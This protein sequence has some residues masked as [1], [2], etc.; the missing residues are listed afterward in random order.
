MVATIGASSSRN[1]RSRPI[2][3]L[4]RTEAAPQICSPVATK[5]HR[6][7][8]PDPDP[9]Q[10]FEAWL[11]EQRNEWSI[12]N[13]RGGLAGDRRL[14]RADADRALGI[15]LQALKPGHTNGLFPAKRAKAVQP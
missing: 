1:G 10:R 9:V 3:S 13:H 4:N 6:Q 5:E 2:L 8:S 15:A 14:S 12:R 7:H 11:C